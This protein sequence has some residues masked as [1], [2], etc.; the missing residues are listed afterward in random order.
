MNDLLV[1]VLL[2]MFV[3]GAFNPF[4]GIYWIL[5]EQ[6]S[7]IDFL[8]HGKQEEHGLGAVSTEKKEA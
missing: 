8:T 1:G 2:G 6:R 5:R 4:K 7:Q 3:L